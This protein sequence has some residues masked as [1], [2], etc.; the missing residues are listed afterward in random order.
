MTA[1]VVLNVLAAAAYLGLAIFAIARGARSPLARPLGLLGGG[2]FLY[3][4]LDLLDDLTGIHAFLTVAYAVAPLLA[5]PLGS[6]LLGFVGERRRFAKFLHVVGGYAAIVGLL[7]LTPLFMTPPLLRT[8]EVAWAL[9]A[10]GCVL[11]V[12]GLSFARLLRHVG[13]SEGAER[14][15]GRLLSAALV[16]GAGSVVF[17]LAAIAGAGLPRLSHAGLLAAASI[18]AAVVLDARLLKDATISSAFA[19]AAM[20]ATAVL[21]QMALVQQVDSTSAVLWLGTIGVIVA[22]MA[23]LRPV[24]EDAMRERAR[25]MELA[26]LGRFTEQMAHDLRNPL[27]AIRGAAELIVAE[28]AAGREFPG[29]DQM[30]SIVVERTRRIERILETYQRL[31]RVEPAFEDTE[32]R[33]LIES[34]VSGERASSPP[35]IALELTVGPHVKRFSIDPDLV[36]HALENL[37]RNAKQS[38]VGATQAAG[39]VRVSAEV[40]DGALSLV[41]ED[42]GPGM[43]ARTRE[44]ATDPFF[45]TKADGSGLGL[46]FVVKVARAHRG[47]VELH[48]AEG[49]GTRVGIRLRSIA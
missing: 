29:T 7:S 35:N 45:T 6:L 43:D 46:A 13:T 49:R 4:S 47:D 5:F 8:G 10:M 44:Q 30:L 12:F 3:H 15:K 26:T 11:P 28:R 39:H 17:D 34:V 16:L 20:A 25:Q 33:P 18:V 37:I 31:G 42:D 48:S 24:A 14:A 9:A 1:Q 23:A 38:I 32:I 36:T 2:L 22:V 21:I 40:E 41:V 19:A 27:A